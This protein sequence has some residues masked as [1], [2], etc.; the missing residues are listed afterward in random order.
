M[1]I[2]NKGLYLS[3]LLLAFIVPNEKSRQLLDFSSISDLATELQDELITPCQVS[4][5]ILIV[6]KNRYD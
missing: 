2:L 5:S 3:P 1:F 4:V 6:K